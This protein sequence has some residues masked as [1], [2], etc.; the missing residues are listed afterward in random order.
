MQKNQPHQ[1]YDVQLGMAKEAQ[2]ENSETPECPEEVVQ[3]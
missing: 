3:F 2:N 1:L